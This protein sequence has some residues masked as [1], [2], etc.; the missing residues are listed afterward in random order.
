MGSASTTSLGFDKIVA[1]LQVYYPATTSASLAKGVQTFGAPA[2]S[3]QDGVGLDLFAQATNGTLVWK[4]SPDG[5]NWTAPSVNLGGGLTS[6]PAATSPAPGIIDVFVRGTNAALYEMKITNANTATPSWAWSKIGGQLLAGT[7]PAAYSWGGTTGQVGWLVTGTTHALYQGWSNN[8]GPPSSWVNLG[9][10]LTSGPAATSPGNGVIGV[11]AGGTNGV[12]TYDH[13]SGGVWTWST[14][15]G[16]LLNGTAP[17][18][19][20]WGPSQIRW[21]VTGTT[22]ALY[23]WTGTGWV[24][25]GGNLTTSPAATSRSSGTID[26]IVRGSDN[27]L[28]QRT[29]SSGGWSGLTSIAM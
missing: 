10:N 29:Y 12:I 2:V 3:S 5:T 22:H 26:V 8:G 9:G 1:A 23:Q 27:G 24:N 14:I 7:G 13:L 11:V 25:L 16:A 6:A 17:A 19:Y 4:H 28:W 15:G 18:A 21:F 20:N